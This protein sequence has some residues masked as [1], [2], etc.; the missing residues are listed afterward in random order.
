MSPRLPALAGA[1]ALL[2][3]AS[4]TP[5]R[6]DGPPAFVRDGGGFHSVLAYGQGQ[7]ASAVDLAR[8]VADGTVPSSFTDQGALYDR[9]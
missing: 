1:L 2:L 9:V 8:N 6:A 3:T 4:P 5:G 7:S